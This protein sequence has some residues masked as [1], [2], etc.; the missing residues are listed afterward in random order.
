MSFLIL[1]L[2]ALFFFFFLCPPFYCHLNKKII[3]DHKLLDSRV[4][5][6]KGILKGQV[7]YYFYIWLYFITFLA[8]TYRDYP[9]SLHN[10]T[11]IMNLYR[12]YVR[13]K[14]SF[15]YNTQKSE[16]IKKKLIDGNLFFLWF[17]EEKV[18]AVHDAS[19]CFFF[20]YTKKG[21]DM[22]PFL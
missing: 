22:R 18:K 21:K 13:N 14:P 5:I 8:P 11:S 1:S 10:I 12:S 9:S 17:L 15:L 3:I 6:F 20:I 16:P 4:C 19:I 2:Y 7:E